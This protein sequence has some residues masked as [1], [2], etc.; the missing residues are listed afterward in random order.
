LDIGNSRRTVAS[1]LPVL[2]ECDL[3]VGDS[4]DY[5]AWI[6]TRKKAAKQHG[7]KE[8]VTC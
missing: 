5:S 3:T 4:A 7:F 8:G 2:Q 1:V 6:E